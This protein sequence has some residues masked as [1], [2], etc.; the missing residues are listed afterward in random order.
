MESR[1]LGVVPDLRLPPSFMDFHML[2]QILWRSEAAKRCQKF[3]IPQARSRFILQTGTMFT[4]SNQK[5]LPAAPGPPN[6]VQHQYPVPAI[7]NFHTQLR[8]RGDGTTTAL[9][10]AAAS[11]SCGGGSAG[12]E[13]IRLSMFP[14]YD[15]VHAMFF[16]CAM[17]F[18]FTCLGV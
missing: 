18:K 12:G 9:P 13:F 6:P 8:W 10:A 16:A 17:A 4:N 7:F 1:R 15:V 5:L 3:Q 2:L 11:S 14:S